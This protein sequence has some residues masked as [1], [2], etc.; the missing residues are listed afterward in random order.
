MNLQN[1]HK[2]T[3]K[4]QLK[5]NPYQLAEDEKIKST[6]CKIIKYDIKSLYFININIFSLH[7]LQAQTISDSIK[8]IK[9]DPAWTTDY[10]TDY[11]SFPNISIE[12]KE[13]RF[14]ISELNQGSKLKN[15]VHNF[16]NESDIYH[17]QKIFRVLHLNFLL[18]RITFIPEF[19]CKLRI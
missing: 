12:I 6:I 4:R 15:S 9:N 3:I 14:N 13:E 11:S 8:V 18:F 19:T 2:K 7:F 10:Y 1:L 17:H 5:N 16:N